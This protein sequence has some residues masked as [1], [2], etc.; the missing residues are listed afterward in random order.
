[1]TA[2][3]RV[4]VSV[5]RLPRVDE[6]G[7][8]QRGKAFAFSLYLYDYVS[9]YVSMSPLCVGRIEYRPYRAGDTAL[10]L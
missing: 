10:C 1:M 5:C 4:S 8:G 7:P 2:D 9:M 3:R 6:P